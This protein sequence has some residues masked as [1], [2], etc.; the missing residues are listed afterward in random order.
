LPGTKIKKTGELKR[1]ARLIKARGKR[2]VFTNGCFDLLHFGHVSYLAKAKARGDILIVGLNSDASVKRIK[3]QKR[4]LIKESDRAGIIAALESVDYVTVFKQ[5]TPLET[6]KELKPDIL[7]KGADWNKN[8][9]VGADFVKSYG[10]KVMT[11]KLARG[12]STTNLIRKIIETQK[13]KL[14]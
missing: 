13:N 11:V 3:G 8:S 2:V 4:P 7:V 1:I 6:I 10:G 5:D 14:H 12:R 9:I